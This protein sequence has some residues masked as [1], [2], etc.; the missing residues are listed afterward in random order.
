MKK[1][2]RKERLELDNQIKDLDQL[3]DQPG[4]PNLGSK[5]STITK[6][7]STSFQRTQLNT[8]C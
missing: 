7:N 8:I 4:D 2:A 5:D 1:K 6:L 3:Y